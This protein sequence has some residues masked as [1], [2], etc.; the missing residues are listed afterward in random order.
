MS[1]IVV[2]DSGFGSLSIIK[3][4]QKQTKAEILY[5]ADQKSFPYGK[6]TKPQLQ[7]IIQTTINSLKKKFEPDLIIVGSNTPSILLDDIIKRERCVIGVYPPIAEAQSATRT[8][9]VALLVTHA[10]ANSKKLNE[11]IIKNLFKKKI[12]IT[13]IDSSDLVDL[14]ESGKFLYDE[15]FC[16]DKINQILRNKF[17]KNNIDVATLSST[18]L[19]FLQPILEKLFPDIIFLDPAEDITKK[20]IKHESFIPSKRNTLSIFSTGDVVTFQKNLQKIGIR[21]S[22]SPIKL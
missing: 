17:K 3:A 18:H 6:K 4:I 20:I 14:I 8:N 9:S 12:K 2:F 21:K 1:K 15:K 11:F 13:K 7:H 22:V 5:V 16:I 10:V 19:P